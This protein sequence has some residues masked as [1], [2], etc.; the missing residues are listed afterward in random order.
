MKENKSE[1]RI[2]SFSDFPAKEEIIHSANACALE[3]DDTVFFFFSPFLFTL[4][5]QNVFIPIEIGVFVLV[6]LTSLQSLPFPLSLPSL[7]I[8]LIRNY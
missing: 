8:K 1:E 4:F 3:L 5:P 2:G 6:L 7:G